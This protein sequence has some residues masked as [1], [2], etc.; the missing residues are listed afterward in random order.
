MA[1]VDNFLFVDESGD[2]GKPFHV[3]ENGRSVPTG[4][5]LYYILAALCVSPKKLH[6]LEHR[7]AEVKS[8]FGYK[9]EIK[10]NDVSLKLYDALLG[11]LNEVGVVTYYRLVDKAAYKGVFAVPGRK[12][13]H[14]IFDEYN[15]V[16]VVST[17]IKDCSLTNTEVIIDRADRRL[18][19]KTFDNFDKYL[20]SKVN[21]RTLTR[22]EHITHVSSEYVHAMQMSDLVCGA[23]KESFTGRNKELIQ[24]IDKR[25][26]VRVK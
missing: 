7:V 26:L 3:D 14:N 22:V 25:L 5:S 4:A 17:A 23:I 2:P 18:L 1:K 8:S 12:N 10:T 16:K 15:L 19:D 13:L 9:K 24:K 6:E 21:T 20:K 11:V